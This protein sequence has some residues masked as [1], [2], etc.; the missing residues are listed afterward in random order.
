MAAFPAGRATSHA[1]LTSRNTAWAPAI[2]ASRRSDSGIYWVSA[3]KWRNWQTRYVQGVVGV[4]PSGF[5]S[6]LRHQT[7]AAPEFRVPNRDACSR[8]WL[9]DTNFDTN[10]A[11]HHANPCQGLVRCLAFQPGAGEHFTQAADRLPGR[12]WRVSCSGPP[13][14]RP[15]SCSALAR[16][17][18]SDAAS[19]RS[20]SRVSSDSSRRA[21]FSGVSPTG[22]CSGSPLVPTQRTSPA[23]ARRWRRTRASRARM[24]SRVASC[25][26][27]GT[28]AAHRGSPGVES[29]VIARPRSSSS[30]SRRS[31]ADGL[32]PPSTSFSTRAGT[33]GSRASRL[34]RASPEY[35]QPATIGWPAEWR[36]GWWS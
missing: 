32:S 21:S 4:F 12:G 8:S 23:A 35:A 33:N 27:A 10:P 11:R 34:R 13:P 19:S 20:P 1:L 16:V 28:G 30:R 14:A 17:K 29:A 3:P 2:P 9:A 5:E 31:M 24:S 18:S 7:T 15:C 36:A 6:L 25:V 26:R 22:S